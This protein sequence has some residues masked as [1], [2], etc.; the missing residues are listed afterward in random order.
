MNPKKSEA[1]DPSTR[2]ADENED[3]IGVEIGD[4]DVSDD[5]VRRLVGIIR[6]LKRRV[7]RLAEQT[8][9]LRR[10]LQDARSGAVHGRESSCRSI[11]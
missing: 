8:T 9:R 1:S 10:Q 7:A 5:T 3:D 4:V 6:T 2:S 11:I